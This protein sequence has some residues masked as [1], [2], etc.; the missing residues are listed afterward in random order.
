MRK[1]VFLL[2]KLRED[3]VYK[4][5]NT[6]S[7]K[8]TKNAI[9]Y[10]RFSSDHQREESIEA[11]QR[12]ITEYANRNNYKIIDWYIDRG[13]S[14]KTVNRP[15]FQKMLDDISSG[16]CSFDTVIIHKMDRFSRNA[17]DAIKYKGILHDYG[18]ELVSTVEQIKDDA[19]GKLVYGIM[20][21]INQFYIDNL[22]N[23][24][25]KGLRENAYQC[26][27][28]GGKPPLGY[29]VE[30][31]K[32]VINESEAVIIRKIFEMSADGYGYNSILKEL[33][34]CGYK[35]KYG[36]PFGKNSLYDLIRNERYY[37]CY[38]YNKCAKRNSQNQRNSHRYK[39]ESEIIRIEGGNPAIISK[40]LWEKANT[41]RK[42]SARN[43]C[44]AK[45]PYLLSG[46][47]YCGECGAK[48][49]GNHRKYGSSGYNTYRC[50][51][52]ANQ[53]NCNCK[54]I[55][56][57]ILEQF[58][59]NTLT[60]HFFN[61]D[62]I[63]IITEQVND[64]I[65]ERADTENEKT[66]TAKSTLKGLETVRNNLVEAMAQAG[67]NKAIADKLEST[68]K[69]IAEYT[70]II[71]EEANKKASSVSKEE[72]ED[73]IKTLKNAMLDIKNIEKTR[74]LLHSYIDKIII[75]NITVKVTFKVA[76]SVFIKGDI[77]TVE[78]E[79][80]EVKRRKEL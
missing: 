68:E 18:I 9:G 39:D 35:T 66:L 58:V 17:V 41:A 78:Y 16:N 72:V 56:S 28:N 19:Q 44:K 8:Q 27:W 36:K 33:N 26:K 50:N 12:I 67:F 55:R 53:L 64:L 51:K 46:L 6:F 54:E 73:R 13:F 5:L 38:I 4:I 30:N 42:I 70:N 14:G 61:P 52:Q 40:E 57:D 25:M 22:S 3:D 76:F 60:E 48:M 47:L 37:G 80:T 71:N 24:V 21:N 11:Q 79:Y 49:H 45:Y 32:L 77:Q 2:M 1:Q 43:N 62:I 75:D 69:Q 74:L 31:G 7:Q 65:K 15:S 10:C 29:N 34:K 63:E 20:S 59:I 23:E